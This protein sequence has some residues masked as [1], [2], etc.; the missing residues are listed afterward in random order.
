VGV[1]SM[2]V[3]IG[4]E[5]HVHGLMIARSTLEVALSF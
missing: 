4:P 2:W 1:A 3:R 5:V